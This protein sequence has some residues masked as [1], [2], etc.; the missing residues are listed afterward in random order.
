MP[1]INLAAEVG[2]PTGSRSS[3]RLRAEGRI[4][5]VVY[6]QGGA[7]VAITVVWRE[8]RHALT[9][10]AG[11]NALINLQ[12]EGDTELTIVKEMQRHPV[13]REVTHVDLL[14][15]SRDEAI[16]VD[17]PIVLLGEAEKVGRVDGVIEHVL[18]QLT[19]TAKPGA[20]PS[21]ISVDISAMEVND[22]IRVG[23]LPLPS[24]V[25]TDVD[26][27]EPVVSARVSTVAQ[28]VE[29]AD[30]VEAAEAEPAADED[31]AE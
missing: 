28:E 17:V 24:G 1:D 14:R 11:L 16:A 31:G 22:T 12:I 13:R 19:I 29:E 23:D 25:E 2:R 9:T 18:H 30:A 4:P 21:E 27:E 8:L 26:P 3:N 6:G 10:D 7:P 5:G 15:I 20:I